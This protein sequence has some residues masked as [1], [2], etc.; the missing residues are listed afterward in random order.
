MW[1]IETII[2]PLRGLG[3][4]HAGWLCRQIIHYC[5]RMIL[6]D[7]ITSLD[8]YSQVPFHSS[9]SWT[10]K[11]SIFLGSQVHANSQTKGLE[12]GWFF[13]SLT[14]PVWMWGLQDLC[15]WDSDAMPV[16]RFWKKKILRKS[17]SV[18]RYKF[19]S[20][21]SFRLR[22]LANVMD[23]RIPIPHQHPVE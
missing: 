18:L 12:W 8:S 21:F 20:F 6:Q 22:S 5:C 13:L 15:V 4:H 17:L 9:S 16:L 14:C 23:G 11:E 3:F 10:T 19:V 7:H 1:R 2:V